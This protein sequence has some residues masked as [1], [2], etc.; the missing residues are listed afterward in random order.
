MSLY[1]GKNVKHE[2]HLLILWIVYFTEY[3]N[4]IH[5]SIQSVFIV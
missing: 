5:K 2:Y 3:N 1:P 4:I